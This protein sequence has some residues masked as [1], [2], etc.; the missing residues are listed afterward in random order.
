VSA[1]WLAGIDG[2]PP[3][4]VLWQRRQSA[5]PCRECG[6]PGV[7]PVGVAVGIGSEVGVEVFVG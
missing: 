4:P 1:A 6:I 5:R 7:I 3:T 2:A